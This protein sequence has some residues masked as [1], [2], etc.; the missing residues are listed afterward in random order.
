MKQNNTPQTLHELLLLVVEEFGETVLTENRLKGLLSDLGCGVVDKYRHVIVRSVNDHLGQKILLLRELDDADFSLKLNNIRQTFQE[1]NF[2]R[3]DIVNY[4]V[5]SYLFA[6]GWIDTLEEYKEDADGSGSKAGEL[7]FAE[8]NDCEYCGNL[9]QED[10]RSGFGI[11]RQDDRSYYAGEWKL[12][13]KNGVGM[14]VEANH[15]KYAG[16]WRFNRRAGVGIQ[17]LTNGIRYAGEW[18]NGKMNGIGI[19]FYPNGERMC[20]LFRNGQPTEDHIGFYYLK[21]GSYVKGHMTWNGPDGN[22]EH[23]HTD[24][25]L[26]NEIWS[27]GYLNT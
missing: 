3:Y 16:E 19:L 7:S 2:F 17:V 13:L 26:M 20:T 14:Q 24:G 23:V 25:S 27:N 22:C 6:L 8:R 5:D 1:D 4:I 21:D 11:S 9:N 15:N 18:K 10:E 12:D